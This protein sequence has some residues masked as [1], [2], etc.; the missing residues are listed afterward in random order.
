VSTVRGQGHTVSAAPYAYPA[1]D[2]YNAGHNVA[3]VLQD[4][5]FLAP[6]LLNVSVAVRSFYGL[7]RLR[8]RLQVLLEQSDLARP[9]AELANDRIALHVAG[10]YSWL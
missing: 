6:G 3:T 2:Q 4:A 9:L 5:D 1:Y 7:Q 10:L 8:D